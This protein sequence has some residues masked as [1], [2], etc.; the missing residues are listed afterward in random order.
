MERKQ[1]GSSTS[2]PLEAKIVD[3]ILPSGG[4]TAAWTSHGIFAKR[5]GDL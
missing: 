1:L 2:L 5:K 4:G 3:G